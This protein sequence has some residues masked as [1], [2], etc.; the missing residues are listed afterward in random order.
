MICKRCQRPI[1]SYYRCNDNGAYCYDCWS[2]GYE[3]E[4]LQ[5]DSAHQRFFM[6]RKSRENLERRIELL[7][8]EILDMKAEAGN[9]YYPSDLSNCR[10]GYVPP[11]NYSA[12]RNKERELD[13]L[14]SQLSS[15][16]KPRY[17]SVRPIFHAAKYYNNQEEE[18]IAIKLEQERQAKEELERRQ[19]EIERQ[20]KLEEEKQKQEEF[21][22]KMAPIRA[23]EEAKRKK[24]EERARK[25]REEE[26]KIKEEQAR[27]ER[28]RQDRIDVIKTFF[29]WLFGLTAVGGIIAVI[30][31]WGKWILAAVFIVI[32]IITL[33]DS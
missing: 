30:V 16:S 17:P 10:E 22:R 19:L 29:K 3:N 21:E 31:L 27:R 28:E 2:L 24:E 13:V 8:K 18:I 26:R 7:H 1:T 5:L 14:R 25:K 9:P 6:D 23:A 33:L 12:V 20:K 15:T 11:Y 4:K 32:L